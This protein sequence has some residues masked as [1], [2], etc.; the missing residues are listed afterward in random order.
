MHGTAAGL[1]TRGERVEWELWARS[2]PGAI[3][4]LGGSEAPQSSSIRRVW[5]AKLE[6]K[7]FVVL[8]CAHHPQPVTII[9]SWTQCS[10]DHPGGELWGAGAELRRVL[11]NSNK[12]CVVQS[13]S[14]NLNPERTIKRGISTLFPF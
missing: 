13:L 3:G 5:D 1:G 12:M 4:V 10:L 6:E 11:G 8:L 14:I 2:H 7:G 9:L